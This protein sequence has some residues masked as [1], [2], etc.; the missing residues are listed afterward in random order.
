MIDNFVFTVMG[1]AIILTIAFIGYE[2]RGK[3][4]CQKNIGYAYEYDYGKCIKVN[5]LT[6]E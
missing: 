3:V 6:K 1:I 4:E 2:Y 5:E